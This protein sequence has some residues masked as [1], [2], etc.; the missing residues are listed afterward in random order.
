[1]KAED[2]EKAI[3]ESLFLSAIDAIVKDENSEFVSDLYV[4]F[5][6]ESGELQ[7]YDE[8]EN[9]LKKEALASWK[10]KSIGAFQLGGATVEKAAHIFAQV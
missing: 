8:N 4:Q 1:M 2:K 6:S 5:D 3:V 9:L 10:D 7:I